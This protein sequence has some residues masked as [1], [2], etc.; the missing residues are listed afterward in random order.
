MGTIDLLKKH[1]EPPAG[2]SGLAVPS[3]RNAG[4]AADSVLDMETDRVAGFLE[5][6]LAETRPG[7]K[8]TGRAERKAVRE[9]LR[10]H[11]EMNYREMLAALTDEDRADADSVHTARGLG[12]LINSMG[13][14][15]AFNSGEIEKSR[16]AKS[17]GHPEIRV[18]ARRSEAAAFVDTENAC[19][20]L[21]CVF[22]DNEAKP[23]TVID[24]SLA[25]NITEDD[26]LPRGFRL[27][28]L[29]SY[30]IGNVICDRL[31]REIDS[32]ARET[33]Q[34]PAD[35]NRDGETSSPENGDRF[36]SINMERI[37]DRCLQTPQ[38]S[39]DAGEVGRILSARGLDGKI[40]LRAF[41]DALGLFVSALSRHG[42]D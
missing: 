38:P 20:V 12:S 24:A 5:S 34:G 39:P 17:F 28:V 7:G 18:A 2:G 33:F 15:N 10:S 42:L 4:N 37:L 19:R 14:T 29:E 23:K 11:I 32:A 1:T 26:L 13:G 22:R 25:I 30:L 40:R 6:A 3:R 16:P 9:R 35:D 41:D 21:S 31:V 27:R 8:P 36:P